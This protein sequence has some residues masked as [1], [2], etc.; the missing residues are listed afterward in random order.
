MRFLT[1]LVLVALAGCASTPSSSS[2]SAG[3]TSSTPASSSGAA[4]P[5]G[6]LP[7]GGDADLVG[8]LNGDPLLEGGC[9]WLV[10]DDGQSW[11]VLWPAGYSLQFRGELTLLVR[12]GEESVAMTGQRVGVDGAEATDMA[13]ICQVG[14]LFQATEVVFVADAAS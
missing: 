10:D 11:E 9:A 13:S 4:A 5:S 14:R 2:S 7:T 6:A 1:S 8:T 3:P 12:D